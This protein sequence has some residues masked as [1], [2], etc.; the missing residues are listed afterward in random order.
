MGR[1]SLVLQRVTMRCSR[2][3]STVVSSKGTPPRGHR[4]SHAAQH[5]TL[6]VRYWICKRCSSPSTKEN[7]QIVN[8]AFARHHQPPAAP[9][10]TFPREFARQ[11]LPS[12]LDSSTPALAHN[13]QQ[14][15]AI[16]TFLRTLLALFVQALFRMFEQ[17]SPTF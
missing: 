11:Q 5:R 7:D 15:V 9:S 4:S 6:M 14:Q 12:I 17:F 13:N 8:S 3:C 10:P 16:I 1:R 2:D